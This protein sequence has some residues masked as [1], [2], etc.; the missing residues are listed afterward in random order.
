[1]LDK[2]FK[3]GWREHIDDPK[4]WEQIDSVPDD[5]LGETSVKLRALLDVMESAT[6]GGDA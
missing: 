2:Y 6:H 5:E 4:T 3:K 1:M